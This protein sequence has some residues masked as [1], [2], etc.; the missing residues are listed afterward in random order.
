MVLVIVCL[1]LLT[2]V[3]SPEPS[4]AA[5]D[6]TA[7][8]GLTT[9]TTSWGIS[10]DWED[11]PPDVHDMTGIDI[12]EMITEIERAANQGGIDLDLTYG[13]E[14]ITHYYVT[15][16]P[17][18]SSEIRLDG[19]ERVNVYSV[20]TTINLRTGIAA[21][22]GVDAA[23]ADGDVGFDLVLDEAAR[24]GIIFD[25]E[26]TEYYT[27]NGDFAGM[28]MKASGSVSFESTMTLDGV[29]NGG[30]DSINFDDTRLTI[31][32]DWTLTELTAEWRMG[33]VSTVFKDLTSGDYDVIE[34]TCV[35]DWEEQ[36]RREWT[37]SSNY[38]S[39]STGYSDR[40]GVQVDTDHD[41]GN[42]DYETW[43]IEDTGADAIRLKFDRFETEGCCDDLTIYD[44]HT[45]D[46]LGGIAGYQGGGEGDEYGYTTPWYATDS[47]RIVWNSDGSITDWGFELDHWESGDSLDGT[48]YLTL[49]DDCGEFEFNWRSSL[50]Y[51]LQLSDFPA[52]DLG[53][54]SDQASFGISDTLSS[55]GSGDENVYFHTEFEVVDHDYSINMPDGTTNDVV[56]IRSNGPISESLSDTLARGIEW[57]LDDIDWE[58][59]GDMEN[60]AED[61][62]DDYDERD[63]SLLD[64]E[65]DF[66]DSDFE[67]D[68]EDFIDEFEENMEEIEDDSDFVYQDADMYWLIDKDSYHYVS[69]Q[70]I[71]EDERGV[72]TQMF[73]PAGTGYAAPAQGEDVEVD[74]SQ[75]AAAE[76]KQSEVEDISSMDEMISGSPS[77]EDS[78]MLYI[79]SGG[80]ALAVLLLLGMVVMVSRRRR[81]GG[82]RG[83]A[84]EEEYGV[85]EAFND[86]AYQQIA[87][88]MGYAGYDEGA[89]TM[90]GQVTQQAAQP[91]G[92]TT[93]TPMAAASPVVPPQQPMAPPMSPPMSPQAR[94]C[95]NCGSPGTWYDQQ[96]WH[97]CELCA[98][99]LP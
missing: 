67:R 5:E 11:L 41:Y 47:I 31:D 98:Q 86:T 17:G 94:I 21:D 92:H 8:A 13:V 15:Q 40:Y 33:E 70:M 90:T 57:S 71:V 53:F 50:S 66:E 22:V 81:R 24:F 16:A 77:D 30:R 27:S 96:Q 6:E 97:W 56:R 42:E 48:D 59:E 63:N 1:L 43:W 28:D 34:W 35:D 39:R 46:Y 29:V 76:N 2:G 38:R 80:I 37:E 84:Y 88:E 20:V 68:M 51:D 18:T 87:G 26:A 60:T 58:L 44:E 10:Y 36:S 91:S 4:L 9:E 65:N 73:G 12:D 72:E 83:G 82:R 64:M 61:W 19:G 78:L 54:T 93:A 25:I 32:V 62:E 52:A 7:Y 3:P 85:N 49:N 89:Q 23:W 95:S 14:G 74:F 45:G 69:P 99:W 75:G 55:S 79:I